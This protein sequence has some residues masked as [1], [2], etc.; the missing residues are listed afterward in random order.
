MTSRLLKPVGSD[1]ETKVPLGS[2][3]AIENRSGVPPASRLV[4]KFR[5]KDREEPAEKVSAKTLVKELSVRETVED[6]SPLAPPN[7]FERST[8]PTA[9]PPRANVVRVAVLLA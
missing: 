3:M 9:P 7:V 8:A 1:V 4:V 5:R 2:V 6:M